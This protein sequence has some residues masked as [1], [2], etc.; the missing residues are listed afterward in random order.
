MN[1]YS[2]YLVRSPSKWEANVFLSSFLLP[3]FIHSVVIQKV[4][5]SSCSAL[6]LLIL[7]FR[8]EF[9]KA[10]VDVNC[11]T[12]LD[13]CSTRDKTGFRLVFLHCAA[14]RFVNHAVPLNMM[15]INLAS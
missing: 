12:I 9:E 6:F 4:P 15:E 3:M 7:L 11:A 10:D 5:S 14:N 2:D 1:R 13:S 8:V